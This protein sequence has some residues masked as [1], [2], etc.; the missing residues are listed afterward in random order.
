[1]QAYLFPGQGSQAQGMGAA[2]FDTVERYAEFESN[3]D[4]IMGY[5]VR[6]LCLENPDNALQLTRNTQ[7]CL[8]VVNALH[9][10]EQLEQH[11]DAQVFAGHSLGEYNAL[12]AA[13]AFGFL[14]GLRLVR[15][16]GEL[17]S[18][19]QDG[20]MLAVVGISQQQIQLVLEEEGG[21][22][23]DIA[24]LN[25]QV[26][27]I[28][29]GPVADLNAIV[30]AMEKAGAKVCIPLAVSAP[31]HSRYM[32][33]VADDFARYLRHFRFNPLTAPVIANASAQPYGDGDPDVTI[34]NLLV[35]QIPGAVDWMRSIQQMRAMGV[36]VFREVGVGSVLTR[37]LGQIP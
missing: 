11:G 25:S 30:P 14:D 26:Q 9:Y 36:S 13:G 35:Q 34:K 23:I 8:Y 19:L 21:G 2:L 3:V 29:S 7:P 10:W 33:T 27:T 6:E 22:S 37:L 20:G 5:S 12:L 4:E 32:L 15:K 31:F 1:M 24:N 16:R 18:R 17:M 28:L